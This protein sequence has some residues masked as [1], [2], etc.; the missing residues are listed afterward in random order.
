MILKTKVLLPYIHIYRALRAVQNW[1][2]MYPQDILELSVRGSFHILPCCYCFYTDH[3][4]VVKWGGNKVHRSRGRGEEEE[5]EERILIEL[6]WKLWTHLHIIISFLESPGSILN[7][8]E[9]DFEKQST[10]ISMSLVTLNKLAGCFWSYFVNTSS[11]IFLFYLSVW[12]KK[13][14]RLSSFHW[15]QLKQEVENWYA[16]FY[17]NL[18]LKSNFGMRGFVFIPDLHCQGY[19]TGWLDIKIPLWIRKEA[20][21]S[22]PPQVDIVRFR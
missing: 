2:C 7:R 16:P 6:F 20:F 12:H 19:T 9:I 15:K 22:W 17:L 13:E 4:E 8:G 18:Y 10:W 11:H 21:F 14:K 1:L 5:G 3:Y